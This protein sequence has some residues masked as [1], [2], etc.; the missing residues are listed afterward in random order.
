MV[1]D[2]IIDSIKKQL[3]NLKDKGYEVVSIDG[4]GKYLDG[5]AKV[6]S[7]TNDV[8]LA[9]FNAQN[10]LTIEQY[11][12]KKAEW[13]ELF[14]ATVSHLQS[15]IKILGVINGGAAVA[16]LAFIGK[17]WS[18]NFY[19]SIIGEYISLA[20]ILY[21]SGVGLAAFTQALT[22]LSQHFFT[23]NCEKT[24]SV[25]RFFGFLSAILSLVLFFVATYI[26]YIGFT[27]GLPV[28]L[29]R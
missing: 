20:L 11:K 5:L 8:Q 22:Y 19:G 10:S 1:S 21:C 6:A 3:I 18:P 9:S 7:S 14:K 26:A 4:L 12:E 13:R 2:Q 28:L 25:V 24:A 29:S 16:L 15:A 17:I 27:G 23:Y